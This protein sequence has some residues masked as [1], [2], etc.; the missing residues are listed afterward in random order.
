MHFDILL[1]GYIEKRLEFFTW[2]TKSSFWVKIL[3]ALGMAGVTG[4]LAQVRFYLP[5]TPVPVV[6]S[7]FGVMMAGVVL[8]RRWGGISM[9]FY[10]LLGLL[11]IPWFAGMKGGAAVLMGPTGGYIIGFILSAFFIG[12]VVDNFA[13]A[14]KLLPLFAIL[15]VSQ[16][17]IIYI[18][19]LIQLGI[20]LKTV[21]GQPLGFQQLLWMG[22]IPFL[23]GDLFK[24][25]ATTLAA[26]AI[27]PMEDFLK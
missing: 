12:Y 8:G 7:Q 9:A 21:K 24:T 22:F 26:K 15:L 23:I 11:G 17:V 2:R 6:A 5:W 14:R 20:Y 10:A 1:K 4:V 13:S 19:G 27:L 25:A 16:M 3:M 18:P